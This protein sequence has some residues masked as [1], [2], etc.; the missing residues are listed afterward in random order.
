MFVD[1]AAAINLTAVRSEAD[2]Y[3]AFSIASH[4]AYVLPLVIACVWHNP[5]AET[6]SFLVLVSSLQYHVCGEY[7]VCM[8][9]PFETSRLLDRQTAVLVVFLIIALYIGQRDRD[10]HPNLEAVADANS[11][12]QFDERNA[13]NSENLDINEG[14]PGASGFDPSLYHLQFARFCFPFVLITIAIAIQITGV[15][16]YPVWAAV[17]AS[18]IAMLCY[19]MLFRVERQIPLGAHRYMIRPLAVHVP[20]LILALGLGALAFFFFFSSAL[21][22]N[23]LA[24]SLWHIAGACALTAAILSVELRP[25]EPLIRLD[26]LSRAGEY[27]YAR[28]ML[29]PAD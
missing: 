22:A 24:H 16:I 18:L 3:K 5:L 14:E 10:V 15:D 2:G 21:D 29:A 19:V 12:R 13:T 7:D 11:V 20:M 28:E 4:L 6:I 8:G 17:I 25:P 23:S 27:S 9:L 26:F 1:P